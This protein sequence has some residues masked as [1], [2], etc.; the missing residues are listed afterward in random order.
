MPPGIL[1]LALGSLLGSDGELV[2]TSI[3]LYLCKFWN[4]GSQSQ[5]III[6][7]VHWAACTAVATCEG[8]MTRIEII[9]IMIR[10]KVVDCELVR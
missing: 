9:H 6:H 10:N 7:I 8:H 1:R 5:G 3:T 2:I 4:L